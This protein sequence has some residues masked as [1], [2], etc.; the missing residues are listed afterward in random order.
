MVRIPRSRDGLKS[1][2]CPRLNFSRIRL[3]WKNIFEPSKLSIHHWMIKRR[4]PHSKVQPWYRPF[5]FR[6]TNCFQVS[7]LIILLP[8][9]NTTKFSKQFLKCPP[10]SATQLPTH[11]LHQMKWPQ[12]ALPKNY[13]FLSLSRNSS[14]ANLDH[15]IRKARCPIEEQNQIWKSFLRLILKKV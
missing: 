15:S 14:K 3:S 8:S 5:S 10:N 7:T 4:C 11:S 6:L 13:L 1:R 9:Q 2:R 12:Q